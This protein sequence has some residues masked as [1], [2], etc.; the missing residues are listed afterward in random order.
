MERVLVRLREMLPQRQPQLQ[1]L[2]KVQAPD[3][4]D[5][6][7]SRQGV[8]RAVPTPSPRATF[9]GQVG[10]SRKHQARGFWVEGGVQT[11]TATQPLRVFLR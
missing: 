5:A 8:V 10:S 7:S 1:L 6:A 3:G 9:G 2:P 4:C 11:H